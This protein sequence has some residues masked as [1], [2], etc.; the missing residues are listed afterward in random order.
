ML[1]KNYK[2]ELCFKWVVS[3]TS[4]LTVNVGRSVYMYEWMNQ[5]EFSQNSFHDRKSALLRCSVLMIIFSTSNWLC[6]DVDFI[7][8]K[9]AAVWVVGSQRETTNSLNFFIDVE[10][11]RVSA[12]TA[13]TMIIHTF[14]T[15]HLG[16]A[17][18][19]PNNGHIHRNIPSAI[20]SNTWCFSKRRSSKHL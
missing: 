5:N 9:T 19:Y 20:F 6:S 3:Q 1:L 4:R 17:Q 13:V 2:G 8:I 15:V 10:H 14:P 7:R 18:L 16:S 12:R 11:S